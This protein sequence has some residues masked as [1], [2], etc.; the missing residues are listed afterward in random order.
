MDAMSD[1]SACRDWAERLG[2]YLLGQLDGTERLRVEDHLAH[3]GGCSAETAE[4]RPVVELLPRLDP[5]DLGSRKEM[6]SPLL[7]ARIVRE[8]TAHRRRR[9]RV[10]LAW[11]AVAC[12]VVVALAVAGTRLVDRPDSDVTS[13]SLVAV[14]ASG[15]SGDADLAERAWG[16]QVSLDLSG[17]T[18]GTD[19][20]AWL[21]RPDGSRVPAGSFHAD[22][23]TVRLTL[24]AALPLDEGSAVGVSTI[25][26]EDVL[27]AS[28][29]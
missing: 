28:L 18:P 16:T 2:P 8:V 14:D 1:T 13:R 20:V 6:P 4:L 24:A 23:S 3:C 29:A 11:A 22:G 9:V 10:R 19:Y 27:R 5:S 12:V 26:G 15:L 21:E 25:E 7:A 17:L